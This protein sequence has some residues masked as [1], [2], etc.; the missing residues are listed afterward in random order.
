M[1]K[2]TTILFILM[3]GIIPLKSCFPDK[4]NY[5][6]KDIMTNEIDITFSSSSATFEVGEPVEFIPIVK[7]YNENQVDTNIYKW[8]YH[9]DEL[10]LV[11]TER[12]MS[13]ILQNAVVGKTYL[14]ICIAKDTTTGASF[15][16]GLSFVV[17]TPYKVGWL[18]LSDHSGKSTL[19]FA[20]E[21][22]KEWVSDKDI[23]RTT[24][25]KDLGFNPRKVLYN[26]GG[27]K[28]I[29]ILQGE[30]GD[31]IIL[32]ANTYSYFGD[33]T[34]DF[35]DHK[36]PEN[37]VPK[38]MM[39]GIAVSAILGED[40]R[41]FTKTHNG[42]AE[43][44]YSYFATVPLTLNSEVL[45]IRFILFHYGVYY[46]SVYDRKTS[47]F[48]RLEAAG[49]QS[50]GK[51]IPINPPVDWSPTT[52]IPSP[53]DLSNY[54][55]LY[56]RMKNSGTQYDI[57]SIIRD[58]ATGELYVYA[59]IHKPTSNPQNVCTRIDYD[60]IPSDTRVLMGEGTIFELLR[61]RP[62][63]FFVSGSDPYKLYY[64]D[65][66]TKKHAVFKEGFDSKITTISSQYSNSNSIGIGLENGKFFI[67]DIKEA[68]I[69][70]NIEEQKVLF[71][72]QF[73]GKIVDIW[74]KYV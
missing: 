56:S 18:V 69:I 25:G 65:P 17:A 32:D 7:Y 51:L 54:D 57:H 30:P 14:G 59:M 5:E 35:V 43:Y 47:C 3:L 16:A 37:F 8:E 22:N 1:K 6:Y 23:Y 74:Y 20:R 4:G 2:N 52:G 27:R 66:R 44:P 42:A 72:T 15:T 13:V 38:Y 11:C 53:N 24:T 34:T 21:V 68:I 61:A 46:P 48:Y 70:S 10:G 41:L 67:L 63:L 31:D 28:E 26:V 71:E 33:F 19:N 55:V 39:S 62:Y 45:D 12:N 9:F 29:R 49:I 40:G 50:A 58:K 60:Q 64:Y 36:C 73:D